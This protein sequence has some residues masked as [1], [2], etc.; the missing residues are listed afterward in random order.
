MLACTHAHA[1]RTAGC[2]DAQAPT[3]QLQCFTLQAACAAGSCWLYMPMEWSP[4]AFSR[5]ASVHVMRV[6]GI[7]LNSTPAQTSAARA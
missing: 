3:C 2:L 7:V 6:R 1:W 4:G 5:A